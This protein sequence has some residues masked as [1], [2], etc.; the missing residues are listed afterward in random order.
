MLQLA[1]ELLEDIEL[2]RGS[3]LAHILKASRLARLVDDD[4]TQQWLLMELHDY[5]DTDL[6]R[7]YMSFTGRWIDQTENTG[8]WQGISQIEAQIAAQE[9]LLASLRLPDLSGDMVSI[10][11]REVRVHQAAVANTIG[12][13]AGIRAKQTAT[14]AGTSCGTRS[15]ISTSASAQAST[16]T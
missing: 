13:L 7:K 9:A 15:A 14:P 5:Y 4:E 2:S 1:T 10:A 16:A 3:A 11:L 12:T 8:Y 6:G